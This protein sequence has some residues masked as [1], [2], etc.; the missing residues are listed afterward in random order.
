MWN[1]S[2]IEYENVFVTLRR[3]S[4]DA[5]DG[6]YLDHA[7]RYDFTLEFNWVQDLGILTSASTIDRVVT[8]AL[9]PFVA[10]QRAYQCDRARAGKRNWISWNDDQR[11][12]G[13]IKSKRND[14]FV[15]F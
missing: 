14:R 4:G 15:R 10:F 13:K 1:R 2:W 12:H 11:S 6:F 8:L 5:N 7:E 3:Y 9:L